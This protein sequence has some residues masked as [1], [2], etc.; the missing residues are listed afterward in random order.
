MKSEF[1]AKQ[2]QKIY[3][4]AYPERRKEEK[5]PACEC[6]WNGKVDWRASGQRCPKC[7]R[8]LT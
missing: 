2:A 1:T 4:E 8:D 3:S 5:V 7:G 6:G